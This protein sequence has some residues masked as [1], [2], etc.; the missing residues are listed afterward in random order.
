MYAEKHNPGFIHDFIAGLIHTED[1]TE[2]L[3]RLG[4]TECS[5][6]LILPP[7][8]LHDQLNRKSQALRVLLSSIPDKI[9][10]RSQ[11]LQT[12]KDI[13]Q[14]IKDL[15]NCVNSFSQLNASTA[16]MVQNK[17]LFDYQKKYFVRSSK[18]FSDSLRNFFRENQAGTVFQAANKL[19]TQT[20]VLMRTIK[21][22]TER[23]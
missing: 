23:G 4:A 13:A 1:I 20:N 9:T 12:I 8:E 16:A 6:F 21:I 5:E 3:L 17:R 22:I 7:V 2:T 10:E 15:L 11:F 18:A 14:S 19:I